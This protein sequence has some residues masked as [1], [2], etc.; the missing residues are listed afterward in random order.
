[1]RLTLPSTVEPGSYIV[2]VDLI[3]E[4]V[5]WLSDLDASYASRHPLEVLTG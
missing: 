2:A 1:V 3:D 4:L 5:C